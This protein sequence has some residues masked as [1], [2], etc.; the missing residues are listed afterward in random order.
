MLLE[1]IKDGVR[2]IREARRKLPQDLVAQDARRL[3]S[4]IAPERQ[5]TAKA[6]TAGFFFSGRGIR[7]A[8]ATTPQDGALQQ[9]IAAYT[10]VDGGDGLFAGQL[11]LHP[12]FA[13]EGFPQQP[14]IGEPSFVLGIAKLSPP[15]LEFGFPREV[16]RIKEVPDR[17]RLITEERYVKDGVIEL[18]MGHYFG[19]RPQVSI[20]FPDG[21]APYVTSK[22]EGCPANWDLVGFS[23][24]KGCL[25]VDRRDPE[26]VFR[27]TLSLKGNWELLV[28]P[29]DRWQKLFARR[30][31]NVLIGVLGYIPREYRVK[32][33]REFQEAMRLESLTSLRFKD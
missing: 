9:I 15:Q 19:P 3:W 10:A 8:E 6:N 7:Q 17:A 26:Y 27:R 25:W 12:Y 22:F 28:G 1:A 11:F 5:P 14:L 31:I 13:P 21:P 33:D 16:L 4:V 24:E 2:L 23:E 20:R 29:D 18:R 30:M 32:L